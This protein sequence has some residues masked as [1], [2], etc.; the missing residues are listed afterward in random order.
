M[1]DKVKSRAHDIVDLQSNIIDI[2]NNMLGERHD[3]PSSEEKNPDVTFLFCGY[4]WKLSAFCVWEYRYSESKKIFEKHSINSFKKGSGKWPFFF[5]GDK[6]IEIPEDC[7]NS[8]ARRKT[9][10]IGKIASKKLNLVLNGTRNK[11]MPYRINMEPIDTITS[12]IKDNN[13]NTIDGPIQI[14]KIYKHLNCLPFNVY[15]PDSTGKITFLGRTLLDYEKNKYL[16][17]DPLSKKIDKPNFTS[18]DLEE[19]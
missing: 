6:D 15:W 12:F 11:G 19:I 1:H 8:G 4:S 13:Y 3:F 7:S 17:I 16:V 18:H 5:T 9:T 2:S 14:L 10:S